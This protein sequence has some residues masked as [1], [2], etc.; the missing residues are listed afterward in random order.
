MTFA[1]SDKGDFG[2]ELEQLG[3][4]VGEDVTVGAY[5]AKGKYPMTDKFR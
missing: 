3:L 4:A 5:D 2:H 1:V